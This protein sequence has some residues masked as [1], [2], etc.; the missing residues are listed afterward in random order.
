MKPNRQPKGS[1]NGG[2]FAPQNKGKV[3]PTTSKISRASLPAAKT[4]AVAA[5][6]HGNAYW[7]KTIIRNVAKNK[8]IKTLY[9]LGDFGLFP[10]KEGIDY[11]DEVSREL[12]KHGMTLVI[13]PGNH[14]DYDQ[15]NS[16]GTDK[17]GLIRFDESKYWNIRFLPRGHVWEHDGDK[18]AAIGGAGSI[19]KLL[20]VE[21]ETWWAGE[22]I[23][24]ADTKKLIDN[25]KS[26]GWDKVDFL[27]T[28]DAPA[29][30]RLESQINGFNRPSWFTVEV[31]HYCW[32]QR[33]LLRD[34]VDEIKPTINLHGHWHSR[35]QHLIDGVDAQGNNYK[36]QVL[37][38]A[39]HG[40]S[41]NSWIPKEGD[42]EQIISGE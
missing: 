40:M 11:V 29:G 36:T 27:L 35:S 5:D 25:V 33:I 30:P 32:K 41:G 31:E 16:M 2:E 39:S 42:I 24:L 1:P 3:A 18:F 8:T 4:Y 28:H 13:L 6:W 7:A 38:L 26:L 14:D 23:T 9:Q 21:G 10:D 19:D 17:N 22:E 12:K 15:L 20:R 34:V 37:G